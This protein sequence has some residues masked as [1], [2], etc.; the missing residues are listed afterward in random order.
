MA[1]ILSYL[2]KRFIFVLIAIAVILLAIFFI[3]NGGK[4]TGSN[5]EPPAD[6]A[7]STEV[8][9]VETAALDASVD[10][11]DKSKADD[12]SVEDTA[13][14]PSDEAPDK[15]TRDEGSSDSAT[16][17]NSAEDTA[18]KTS[19]ESS[20]NDTNDDG[21]SDI[22]DEGNSGDDTA[23]KNSESSTS[24]QTDKYSQDASVEKND[25]AGN[26]P[27]EDT[28]KQDA[29]KEDTSKDTKQTSDSTL[30]TSIANL[31][32][33][34]DIVSFSR[35]FPEA[36]AWIWF[37][38]GRISY[39]V[40]QTSDNTKYKSVDYTGTD[41]RTGSIFMDYRSSSDFSDPNTIIYG[42][43]MGDGSMFGA[44]KDYRYNA[45]FLK[46][47]EYFRIITK[48]G[49]IRYR[50]F[51]FM[52]LPKSSSLYNICGKDPDM[53]SLVDYLEYRTYVDSG[54]EAKVSDQILMLSTCTDKD[55]LYFAVFAIRLD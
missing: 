52:D 6:T 22:A 47:H 23:S 33:D 24:E 15:D 14:E 30:D 18:S 7:A 9:I 44:F 38:D 48:D 21:S 27:V 11:S 4:S 10:T 32:A 45:S 37:E 42:H 28:S 34:I 51:A 53:K 17:D 3:K 31:P 54:I 2:K 5:S 13:S 16:D 25:S 41:A 46:G 43:N 55:D 40:M 12:G 19:D 1:S 26:A 39:P 35:D 36:V 49:V 20:G 8:S 50:I 29:P